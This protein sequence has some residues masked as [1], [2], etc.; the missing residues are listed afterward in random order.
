MQLHVLVIRMVGSTPQV[1][2]PFVG[3]RMMQDTTRKQS[4]RKDSGHGMGLEFELDVWLEA[5]Q[6]ES[7]THENNR[8]G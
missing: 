6:V 8:I 4:L 3:M 2:N 1:P 7:K 5:C